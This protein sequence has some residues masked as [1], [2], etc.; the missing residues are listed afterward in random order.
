MKVEFVTHTPPGSLGGIGRYTQ[1]VFAR[2][3]LHLP[4]RLCMPS[5]PPFAGRFSTL[6][7]F[8][9]QLP[10]HEPGSLVHFTQIMGCSQMIW[11]PLH[12]AVATVHD[13]GVLV[14]PEDSQLFNRLDRVVLNMQL[15]GLKRM[16]AWIADSEFTR[17]GMVEILLLP[18]E[19]VHTIH[20]GIDRE[21]YQCIPGARQALVARYPFLKVNENSRWLLYVGNELPR[22]NL[23]VLFAA[24]DELHQQNVP[25]ILIK[26]GTAGGE[27]WR[28]RFI[29]D[30][31]QWNVTP[32]VTI[33]D[34]VSEAEL[35]SFYSAADL[36]VH[37]S[38]LEGFGFPVLEAMACGL[39]V[40]CSNAG[41]LPEIVGKAAWLLDPHKPHEWAEAIKAALDN[42]TLRKE[43]IQQ[44]YEQVIPFTWKRTVDRLIEVYEQVA[45]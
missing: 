45:S 38:L 26:I 33:I 41:S 36:Y 5:Y 19:K 14:C 13:L 17:R 9:L 25:V 29:H 20:L 24:L 11:N 15:F 28:Q 12:P 23:A 2:M 32:F 22:K 10:N 40:I 34:Q 1:E 8:P 3:A 16:D 27:R 31:Q 30:M 21:Q 6:N 37:P 4:T 39:P 35:P 43:L 7:A 44:G 18:Q 42:V